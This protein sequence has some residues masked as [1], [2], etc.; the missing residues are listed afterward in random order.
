MLARPISSPTSAWQTLSAQQAPIM[1]KL[2]GQSPYKAHSGVA[3]DPYGIYL[4][5]PNEPPKGK[6]IL[7]TNASDLGD[8]KVAPTTCQIETDLLYPAV[9]GKD[10]ARWKF[11][12]QLFV[13]V[14]NKSPRKEDQ[15]SESEMR[16]LYPKA[17]EYL[18][19]FKLHLLNRGKLWA[20]YGKDTDMSKIPSPPGDMHFQRKRTTSA[21]S[22]AP[23][24]Q[25]IDVPFYAM[26]DIGDYSFADFKVV[27]QMGATE[28]KAAVLEPQKISIGVRPVLP[29]TGTVSY[30]ACESR[31]EAYY[32]SACLNS[33][34]ANIFF[35]SFSSAGRGMGAPS[36]LKQIELPRFNPSNPTHRKLAQLAAECHAAANSELIDERKECE[37]KI[38]LTAGALW[39]ISPEELKRL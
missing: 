11:R 37:N 26:R 13:L 33:S 6:T 22:G 12:T 29:C 23:V 21:K 36:I 39:R 20:F 27:W 25:M 32:I 4:V 19:S 38:D 7:V 24:I 3:V 28:I 18:H 2:K 35:R 9:R 1:D 15:L 14:T 31:D 17:F 8:I 16:R 5:R 34:L 30:I 10:I